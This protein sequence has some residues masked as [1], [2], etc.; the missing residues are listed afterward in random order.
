M[1]TSN[2]TSA[3]TIQPV[4]HSQKPQEK[5]AVAPAKEPT[6][7]ADQTHEEFERKMNTMQKHLDQQD[8]KL[9]S[10]AASQKLD[11]ET[12]KVIVRQQVMLLPEDQIVE[13]ERQMAEL[14]TKDNQEPTLYQVV[15]RLPAD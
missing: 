6:P 2:D 5:G 14:A 7:S 4:Q 13:L 8:S 10:S 12:L 3:A 11:N 1:R 15:S 9:Q